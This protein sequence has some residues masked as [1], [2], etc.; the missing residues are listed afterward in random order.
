MIEMI[1]FVQLVLMKMVLILNQILKSIS[2]KI[3]IFLSTNIGTLKCDNKQR[4]TCHNY[5]D[6]ILSDLIDQT[7]SDYISPND[8]SAE[9]QEPD[10]FLAI[11]IYVPWIL[12]MFLLC[13]YCWKKNSDS[14]QIQ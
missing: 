14:Y 5:N 9:N 2:L 11:L 10:Y 13:L 4:C 8:K 12:I 7:K 6:L 1:V 3:F